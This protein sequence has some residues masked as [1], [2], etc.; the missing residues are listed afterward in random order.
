[1]LKAKPKNKETK[2]KLYTFGE[3]IKKSV[4]SV[5]RSVSCTWCQTSFSVIKVK[6]RLSD[7]CSQ[8]EFVLRNKINTELK[9]PFYTF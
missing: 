8:L 4:K 9:T 6:S 2:Q 5:N 7:I 1:M 3:R